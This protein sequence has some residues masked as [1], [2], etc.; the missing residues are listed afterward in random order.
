MVGELYLVVLGLPRVGGEWLE[1]RAAWQ[2]CLKASI[3]RQN[4]AAHEV[5]LQLATRFEGF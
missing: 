5:C 3:G 4:E 1:E 2:T